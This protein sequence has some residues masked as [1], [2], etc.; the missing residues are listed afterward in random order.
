MLATEGTVRL[1][2]ELSASRHPMSAGALSEAT[3]LER[4]TTRRALGVLVDAGITSVHGRVKS[5][6]Y[7]LRGEHPLAPAITALFRAERERAEAVLDG[8]KRAVQH[9][10]PP[11]KAAW[12]EGAVAT[13][14]D[15][16]GEP[17]VVR[18]INSANGILQSVTQLREALAPLEQTLDVTINVVGT[19]PADLASRREDDQGWEDCLGS[20]RSLVGLPPAAFLP[21]E[22]QARPH[23]R[24]H[25]DLDA[26]A[27]ALAREIARRLKHDPALAGRA[28]DFV[29]NRLADASSGER[30]ELEE[31][32]QLLQTASP[33]RIRRFLVDPG[34]RATR[35]RQTLP[36]VGM[37]T[38]AERNSLHAA[39]EQG[40]E[41]GSNA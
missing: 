4:S 37:L 2:R 32:R 14:T 39:A 36:F 15:E 3:R 12:L 33:M 24:S 22:Q 30:Q 35:L 1:L 26:R 9:L 40:M 21:Q 6:Q 18:V 23:V 8:I 11:P 41:S 17:L 34:E 28:L 20:A 38:P 16:P 27:H 19:T 25:A 13:E 31:W 7:S 5:P 10:S 29:E